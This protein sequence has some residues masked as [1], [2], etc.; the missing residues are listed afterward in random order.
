MYENPPTTEASSIV[1]TE[2]GLYWSS[3][4]AKQC[5]E[6][7]AVRHVRGPGEKTAGAEVTMELLDGSS[8]SIWVEGGDGK[9]RDVY[10][11]VRFLARVV[12]LKRKERQADHSA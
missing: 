9:Y 8:R 2:R 12:E 7:E 4:E 10:S 5:V 1:I 3:P 11:M 6:F